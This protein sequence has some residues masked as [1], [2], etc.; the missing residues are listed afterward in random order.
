M[1]ITANITFIHVF[2]RSSNIWPSYILN[3][4]FLKL[5]GIVLLTDIWSRFSREDP[6]ER[7]CECASYLNLICNFILSGFSHWRPFLGRISDFGIYSLF[8]IFGKWISNLRDIKRKGRLY[9]TIPE[10]AKF[11]PSNILKCM[12]HRLHIM[13]STGMKKNS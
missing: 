5:F 12:W 10:C 7:G 13:M 2:I 1:H 11:Y 9:Q 3:R 6:W 4:L 8:W